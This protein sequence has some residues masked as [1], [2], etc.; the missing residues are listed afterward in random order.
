MVLKKQKWII[1][2]FLSVCLTAGCESIKTNALIA[3]EKID[4]LDQWMQEH[5]W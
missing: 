2:L 1:L 3:K 5:M 4:R